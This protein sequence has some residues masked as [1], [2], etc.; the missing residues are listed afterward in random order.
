MLYRGTSPAVW[1]SGPDT[2]LLLLGSDIL[3]RTLSSGEALQPRTFL[4]A[5]H[6]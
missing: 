4:F 5:P 6:P 1:G 3:P 2:T